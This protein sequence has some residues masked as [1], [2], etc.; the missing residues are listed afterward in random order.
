MVQATGD[1]AGRPAVYGGIVEELKKRIKE[2]TEKYPEALLILT[3]LKEEIE[4]V[5]HPPAND[6]T[7]DIE[8]K[9]DQSYERILEDNKRSSLFRA[10]EVL[11]QKLLLHAAAKNGIVLKPKA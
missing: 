11:L 3:G 10:F 8:A 4:G 1:F 6:D 9:L 7:D 2:F 5:V